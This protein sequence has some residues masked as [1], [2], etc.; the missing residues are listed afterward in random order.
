MIRPGVWPGQWVT[1]GAW[2]GQVE[3]EIAEIEEMVK[4]LRDK[5]ADW[6]IQVKA[7]VKNDD[8]GW[9]KVAKPSA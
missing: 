9:D 2:R 4:K 7:E 6:I 5:D 3:E 8:S 1:K